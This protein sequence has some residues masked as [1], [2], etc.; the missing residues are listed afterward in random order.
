M[1]SGKDIAHAAAG[2]GEDLEPALLAAPEDHLPPRGHV[3]AHARTITVGA[4]AKHC[5]FPGQSFWI[6]LFVEPLIAA[7]G[8]S[9]AS[10]SVAYS[11]ATLVSATWSTRIGLIADR[12]GVRAALLVASGGVIVGTLLLSVVSGFVGMAIALGIV[13][14]SGQGGMP[15][16]GT[17][18]IVRGMA[19]PRGAAMGISNSVLTLTGAVIPLLAA[20]GI[21]TLG[22]RATLV[23][24][25]ALVAAL[26]LLQFGLMRELPHMADRAPKTTATGRMPLGSPGI[27]LLCVLGLAPLTVTAVVFHAGYYG[28]LAG[29]GHAGVA[30]SLSMLALFGVV[31]A[32]SAGWVA[33]RMGVRALLLMLCVLTAA[34]PVAIA[35]G[36]PVAF[37]VGFAVIGV[38]SGASGVAGSVAWSRTYG[39]DQ[40]GRLQG[41]GAAGVI[42]GASLGPLVPAATDVLDQPPLVGAVALSMLALLAAPFA[43]RWRPAR[44][45]S[46]RAAHRR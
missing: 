25:A 42:V 37:V 1:T 28:G 29:I 17:L 24:A 39:D 11:C 40:I 41:I 9:R 38:A 2:R 8:M 16:V 26:T 30:A 21:A 45:R 5:S 20:A 4:L 10:V 33:D 32:L 15:L 19:E 3:R 22:W 34:A 31:G 6:S 44:S 7:T 27:I 35:S 46:S 43:L 18:A 23:T 14:A 13:R 36:V 12:R